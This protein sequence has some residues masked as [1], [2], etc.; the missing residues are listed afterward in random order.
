MGTVA[1]W[2]VIDGAAPAAAA[3]SYTKRRV[4]ARLAGDGDP[5]EDTVPLPEAL[6]ISGHI[7]GTVSTSSR[8]LAGRPP[9]RPVPGESPGHSPRE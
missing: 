6:R 5:D 2:F 3:V 8:G 7:P 4:V 9:V 1:T